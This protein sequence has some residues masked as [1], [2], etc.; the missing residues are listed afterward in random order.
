MTGVPVTK[1]CD[2]D[3]ENYCITNPKLK[4]TVVYKSV[5]KSFWTELI[6]NKHSMRSNTKGY[7]DKTH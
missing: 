4:Q 7:G 5:S 2:Y 1:Y 3:K 6:N